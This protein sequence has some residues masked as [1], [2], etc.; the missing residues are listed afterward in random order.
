MTVLLQHTATHC[1]TCN[2]RARG[3]FREVQDTVVSLHDKCVHFY[4]TYMEVVKISRP[5]YGRLSMIQFRLNTL[6]VLRRERDKHRREGFSEAV[7]DF[8]VGSQKPTRNKAV[9]M[10][11]PTT[12][13]IEKAWVLQGSFLRDT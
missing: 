10:Q 12:H 4:D 13:S 1:N 8:I 6:S 11:R 2:T 5:S 9:L 3:G 7:F